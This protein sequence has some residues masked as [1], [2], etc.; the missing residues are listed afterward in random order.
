MQN[1]LF[2]VFKYGGFLLFLLLEGFCMYLVVQYNHRQQEIYV[3]SANE[4]S[5]A[6]YSQ[7]DNLVK[8]TNLSSVADSLAAENAALRATLRNAQFEKTLLRDTASTKLDSFV[9][10]YTFVA[11]KVINNSVSN[12]NN[13][14]TIN[15]GSSDG[16]KVGMGVISSNGVVGIVRGVSA[17][18][19]Q[20]MSILHKQTRVSASLKHN[21]YFG[22]LVWRGNDPQFATLEDIPKHADM[23]AGDTIQ[24]SGLSTIF[25]GGLMIGTVE[26]FR[27]K[28]GSNFY[29]IQVKLSCDMSNLQYVYVVDNLFKKEQAELEKEHRNE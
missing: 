14:I 4:W 10:Q 16:V 2:L 6:V 29:S 5:G 17:H 15:R 13:F 9:Q 25:P 24:A 22:S 3:S 1:I 7:Y 11:A 28:A 12:N 23:K 21:S 26:S 8:Y 18:F 20:I 19:A 27:N